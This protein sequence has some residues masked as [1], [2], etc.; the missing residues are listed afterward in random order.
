MEPRF[1]YDFSRVRVHT[2][3]SAVESAAAIGA[4]AYTSGHDVVFAAGEFQPETERG[5]WLLAHELTHVGQQ[6]S[7]SGAETLATPN[8]GMIQKEPEEEEIEE[9]PSAEEEA[10]DREYSEAAKDQIHDK[11]WGLAVKIA[12]AQVLGRTNRRQ[13]WIDTLESKPTTMLEAI[14]TKEEPLSMWEVVPLHDLLTRLEEEVNAEDAA[15]YALWERTNERYTSERTR[16]E[17][18]GD[19]ESE[20]ALKYLDQAFDERERGIAA[21]VETGALVQ[22]DILGVVYI[23]DNQSHVKT[24]KIVAERERTEAEARLD[25]LS[26]VEEEGPGFLETA[27]SF[28]GCDSIGECLGDVALTVATAGTG[29][30]LKF[31]VKGAKAV[32]KA[33]KVRKVVRSAKKLGSRLHK[34]LKKAKALDRFIGVVKGAAVDAASTYAKWLKKDWK[35]IAPKIST[36]LI[37]NYTTGEKK[38]AATVSTA[39]INKEFIGTQVEKVLGIAK[40]DTKTIEVAIVFF[41]GKKHAVASS[42]ARTFILQSLKYRTTVNLAFE[43]IRAGTALIEADEIFKRTVTSTIA[44]AAQDTVQAIPFVAESGL[45][46]YITEAIRKM[47][48]K[49]FG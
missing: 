24:A 10:A 14:L 2:D 25:K 15:A 18:E 31:V 47:T 43:S 5:R 38:G 23:L 49:I 6:T 48:Q 41:L 20:L 37:A 33:R 45:L 11:Y 39:R 22:E 27:W 34:F 46:K 9:E 12:K 17:D 1:G 32:K 26:E 29:K 7:F 28:V 42:L 36:D 4:R 13:K 19:Y 21:I 40:P 44:E 30:A 3:P 35:K 8:P 16:L